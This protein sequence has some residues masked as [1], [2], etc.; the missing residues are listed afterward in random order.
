MA[1]MPGWST[2]DGL[3]AGEQLCLCM[4]VLHMLLAKQPYDL[5]SLDLSGLQHMIKVEL[6]FAGMVWVLASS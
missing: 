3:V 1:R 6:Y 4:C 2:L 5:V